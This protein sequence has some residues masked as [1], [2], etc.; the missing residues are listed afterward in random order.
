M[1]TTRQAPSPTTSPQLRSSAACRRTN[2][3][4]P[5]SCQPRAHQQIRIGRPRL[6]V[7][8]SPTHS[9]TAVGQ[10]PGRPGRRAGVQGIDRPEPPAAPRR[11]RR[12]RPWPAAAPGSAG[13]D[14]GRC[15]LRSSTRPS[16]AR[17][18]SSGCT[19]RPGR[20]ARSSERLVERPD[21]RDQVPRL[22]RQGL[23]RMP[24]A[25]SRRRASRSRRVARTARS[26]AGNTELPAR[27][28]SRR[29][30]TS[31][32][33]APS[34]ESP[35]GMSMAIS[36]TSGTARTART[37]GSAR[38]VTDRPSSRA[39]TQAPRQPSTPRTAIPA[40]CQTCRHARFRRDRPCRPRVQGAPEEG[41]G[42]RRPRAGRLRGLRVRRAGRLPALLLRGGGAD[43]RRARQPRRR[44]RGIGQR[45]ADRGQQGARRP[46]RARLEHL[47]RAAGPAAQRR[48]RRRR[49]E[50]GSTPTT[51]RPSWSWS[52]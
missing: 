25:T 18:A 12:A 2:T 41:P 33:R 7:A 10:P 19:S 36:S 23:A 8:P 11:G 50:P 24:C 16:S 30:W 9:P 39:P 4:A 29:A 43:R 5:T 26:G 3:P 44:H 51:R 20:P 31:H 52:S 38:S 45:R 15:A 1:S 13:R 14:L 28:S 32:A 34:S 17:N 22:H 37:S 46:R 47:D 40:A 35:I 21:G 48:E 6:S 42:R 49:S 27:P